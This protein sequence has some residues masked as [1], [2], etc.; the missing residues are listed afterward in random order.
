MPSE[1]SAPSVEEAVDV[2]NDEPSASDRPP[3]PDDKPG[4]EDPTSSTAADNE[5][6]DGKANIESEKTNEPHEGDRSNEEA[7]KPEN[8]DA[9]EATAVEV[10][11]TEKGTNASEETPQ[12]QK[13]G[14]PPEIARPSS[15]NGIELEPID[16]ELP[17]E[18]VVSEEA[19][20]GN[21]AKPTEPSL[22]DS[23]DQK[24]GTLDD[25]EKGT[26][27]A[28]DQSTS[29]KDSTTGS[30]IDLKE[31]LSFAAAKENAV[32]R[33]VASSEDRNEEIQNDEASHDEKSRN[34]KAANEDSGLKGNGDD[35]ALEVDTPAIEN[36]DE[37]DD[38]PAEVSKEKSNSSDAAQLA[39]DSPVTDELWTEDHG[40]ASASTVPD[41][42]KRTPA[43][44]S[45]ESTPKDASSAEQAPDSQSSTDDSVPSETSAEGTLS[46]V[47]T[48]SEPLPNPSA[49]NGESDERAEEPETPA[50]SATEAR[51]DVTPNGSLEGE[52]PTSTMSEAIAKEENATSNPIA[53]TCNNHTEGSGDAAII[54]GNADSTPSHIEVQ[55]SPDAALESTRAPEASGPTS[56]DST[57][58]GPA[59]KHDGE[60]QATA[61]A[62]PTDPVEPTSKAGDNEGPTTSE[63]TAQAMSVDESAPPGANGANISSSDAAASEATEKPA[64]EPAQD[65]SRKVEAPPED[66]VVDPAPDSV[67]DAAEVS[68]PTGESDPAPETDL[69]PTVGIIPE[70]AS[71]SGTNE[72]IDLSAKSGEEPSIETSPHVEAPAESAPTE[73]PPEA[74]IDEKT[75]ENSPVDPEPP[76]P[77][78]EKKKRRHRASFWGIETTP[79]ETSKRPSKS[80]R[81]SNASTIS[82][83]VR[84]APDSPRERHR[85][86]HSSDLTKKKEPRTL[87][88]EEERRKRKEA[89]E[90]RRIS[91]EIKE[92]KETKETKEITVPSVE[93]G[94]GNDKTSSDKFSHQRHRVWRSLSVQ[95]AGD[96]PVRPKLSGS[97]STRAN[98]R[99]L[100]WLNT[101]KEQEPSRPTSSRRGSSHPNR[102]PEEKA[103]S[104]ARKE[105]RRQRE[106]VRTLEAQREKEAR[107]EARRA[108]RALE[109]ST[110]P[111]SPSSRSRRKEPMR[112]GRSGDDR[113]VLQRPIFGLSRLKSFFV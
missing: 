54:K 78:S 19:N 50:D 109:E 112:T 95:D 37:A 23:A 101:N 57:A 88:D 22:H 8:S 14:P 4:K 98:T 73:V 99:P 41:I 86:H 90:A 20:D 3:P 64:S 92:T 103:A 2:N 107:R 104:K 34:G 49:S 48:A 40:K 31:E 61:E 94:S 26:G 17:G 91:K 100:P 5:E 18:A 7:T 80:R 29:V 43:T 59:S 82:A 10:S 44:S 79:K 24:S 62:Q 113:D 69:L 71:S 30:S 110:P 84:S 81:E 76:S 15:A 45:E 6:T 39:S 11:E 12:T 105:G 75:V 51:P 58:T 108:A 93:A 102:S 111:P 72:A 60:S 77:T 66:S 97:T 25:E 9:A 55:G 53:N 21:D 52:N 85:R 68:V 74:K 87:E 36:K 65:E 13:E 1:P 42:E 27:V 35:L 83:K 70:G 33:G 47:T 56:E 16:P 106:E 28:Q 32:E 96:N 46:S 89:K 63:E 38:K 67:P